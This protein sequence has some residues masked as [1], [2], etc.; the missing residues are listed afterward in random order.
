M[1]QPGIPDI[2]L[3]LQRLSDREA[4]AVVEAVASGRIGAEDDSYAIRKAVGMSNAMASELERVFEEIRAIT[5]GGAAANWLLIGLLVRVTD[6]AA[7]PQ[8][9][10]TAPGAGVAARGIEAVI[11]ERIQRSSRSITVLGYAVTSAADPLF[12]DL[13]AAARRAVRVTLVMDRLEDRVAS[14]LRGWPA[15]AP[16]PEL[17]SRPADPDDAMSAMHAKVMIFDERHLLVSSANLTFHGLRGNL[18]LGV[19]LEG[20]IAAE[21][22]TLIA[23][24][25]REGLV[26]RVS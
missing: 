20:P 7:P 16:R 3:R 25:I 17:W 8:L 13:A 19:L 24:W 4:A 21:M 26:R 11:R 5:G 1:A 6:A 9:V 15:D 23:R 18:E 14:V 12:R 2:A 10:W 22:T